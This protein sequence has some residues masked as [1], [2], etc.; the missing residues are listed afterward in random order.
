MKPLALNAAG[1]NN[2]NWTTTQFA[3]DE[4]RGDNSLHILKK[5]FKSKKRGLHP[6]KLFNKFPGLILQGIILQ[7]EERLKKSNQTGTPKA[8]L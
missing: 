6:V 2:L 1:A 4:I 8:G 3:P 7:M 5:I